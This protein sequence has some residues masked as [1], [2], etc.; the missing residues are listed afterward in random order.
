MRREAHK[1]WSGLKVRTWWPHTVENREAPVASPKCTA[2][3]VLSLRVPRDTCR[4]D[5]KHRHQTSPRVFTISSG[6]VVREGSFE[7]GMRKCREGGPGAEGSIYLSCL[8]SS[9][10]SCLSLPSRDLSRLP[11]DLTQAVGCGLGPT[12]GLG[13]LQDSL[14]ILPRPK[15]FGQVCWHRRHRAQ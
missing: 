14:R 15:Y 9:L 5:I 12:R 10:L 1:V 2:V 3:K 7:K 4:E 8:V 13:P 6:P 11:N